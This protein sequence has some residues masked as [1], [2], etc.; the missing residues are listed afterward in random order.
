ML[1]SYIA[2][3]LSLIIFTSV[4]AEDMGKVTITPEMQRILDEFQPLDYSD[5]FKKWEP[6]VYEYKTFKKIEI[7]PTT[8]SLLTYFDTPNFQKFL[9]TLPNVKARLAIIKTELQK[10]GVVVKDGQLVDAANSTPIC[11]EELL[12]LAIRMEHGKSATAYDRARYIAEVE[13]QP[14]AEKLETI[15]SSI[16]QDDNYKTAFDALFAD[17]ST[18]SSAIFDRL[19][20]ERKLNPK[21]ALM[22]DIPIKKHYKNL[23]LCPDGSSR[24]DYSL[25][26]KKEY[27]MI[28]PDG[29]STLDLSTCPRKKY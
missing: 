17:F 11:S 8:D 24:E 12:E 4:N 23:Y 7:E 28:C 16:V 6:P 18:N 5:I 29:S 21:A 27:M 14:F 19:M 15:A 13:R 9:D 20:L 10:Q 3:F 25:C 2:L 26:P 22:N 1:K